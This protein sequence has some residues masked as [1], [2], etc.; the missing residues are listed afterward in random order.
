M[1]WELQALLGNYQTLDEFGAL[2]GAGNIVDSVFLSLSS[3]IFRKVVD[4]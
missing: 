1:C 4:S 3:H 2:I